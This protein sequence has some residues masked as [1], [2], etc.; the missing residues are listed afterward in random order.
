MPSDGVSTTSPLFG[1]LSG[2]RGTTLPFNELRIQNQ[3]R[4]LV[5]ASRGCIAVASGREKYSH[6]SLMA[7]GNQVRGRTAPA[8]EYYCD[9]T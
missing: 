2:T 1:E 8:W 3:I 9:G 5:A 6:G 4:L 7:S